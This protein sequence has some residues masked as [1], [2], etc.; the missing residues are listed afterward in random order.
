[1]FDFVCLSYV[2]QSTDIHFTLANLGSK[3]ITLDQHDTKL[4]SR[5]GLA[6]NPNVDMHCFVLR[7]TQPFEAMT[8]SLSS[9]RQTR[10]N[11]SATNCE[12]QT[13]VVQKNTNVV[14]F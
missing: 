3:L 1:M 9:G 11:S 2:T 5:G 10:N 6:R 4:R 8:N 13:I 14:F 7:A 12:K